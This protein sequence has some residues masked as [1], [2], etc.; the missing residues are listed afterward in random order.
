MWSRNQVQLQD[1]PNNPTPP[2][3]LEKEPY[4]ECPFFWV[5]PI[6][7]TRKSSHFPFFGILYLSPPFAIKWARGT[8]SHNIIDSGVFFVYLSFVAQS[9]QLYYL[10]LILSHPI[11]LIILSPYL[12]SHLLSYFHHCLTVWPRHPVVWKVAHFG[13]APKSLCMAPWVMGIVWSYWSLK[14]PYCASAGCHEHKA[15]LPAT[16]SHCL[17]EEVPPLAL[18]AALKCQRRGRRFCHNVH[19]GWGGFFYFRSVNMCGLIVV[20]KRCV[21]LINAPT[22]HSFESKSYRLWLGTNTG[23]KMSIHMHTGLNWIQKFTGNLSTLSCWLSGLSQS[24]I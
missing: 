4:A 20:L 8:L 15:N 14:G 9:S 10:E 13:P 19:E 1:K 11:Y 7:S 5:L 3:I 21:L 24:C 17:N 6:F 22:P 12:I 16:L 23:I 18:N 2:L